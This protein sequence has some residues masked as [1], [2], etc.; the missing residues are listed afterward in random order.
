MAG[1]GRG[2][3]NN[4]Q[5]NQMNQMNQMGQMG[6]MG[7][8]N[9]AFMNQQMANMRAQPG[10]NMQGGMQQQMAMGNA[11]IHRQIIQNLQS[12]G[13]FSG[14]QAAVP[15]NERA[16][17]IRQLVDSLRLVRPPV[18]PPKAAEV[19]IQFE[20]KAFAQSASKEDYIRECNDKLA[21]IRDQRAQQM[22]VNG[23][24]AMQQGGMPMQNQAFMQQ[25]GQN[26]NISQGMS[27]SPAQQQMQQNMFNQQRSQNLQQT[28]VMQGQVT[29]QGNSGPKQPEGL[30]QEDNQIINQRAA[31]LAK[32]TPKDK[33]RGIV[34]NMNAQLRASLEAKGVDPIIYYFR[35]M[36]TK[37]FRRQ[38]EMANPMAAQQGQQGQGNF[39]DMGRFQSQQNEA[40]RSQQEG[41]MVVP[42]SN[43]Q[44]M[45]SDQLRLQ[46]QMMANNQRMGQQP[47]QAMLE[48]QRQMQIQANKMQQARQFGQQQ[49]ANNQGMAPNQTPQQNNAGF[50]M[51]N[52][53]VGA[54]SQDPS[55]QNSRPPSRVPQQPNMPQM[56]A[57]D[58]QK[59]E[60]M[61]ARFPPQL[62]NVLRQKPQNEWPGIIQNWQK[63]QQRNAQAGA[64]M[65]Q[66]A[67]QG[68]VNQGMPGP[69][70][71]QQSLSQGGMGQAE[72]N[73]AMQNM[74]QNQAQMN[75]E[76]MRQRAMQQQQQ[77]RMQG[78]AGK[79]QVQVRPL[80]QGE[81]NIMDRAPV[82]VAVLQ[83]IRDSSR[84]PLPNVP[85][86]NW[87][88]LK[89]WAQQNP[90]SGINLQTLLRWQATQYHTQK[91]RQQQQQQQQQQAQMQ[92]GQPQMGQRQ[93]PQQPQP[94][95]PQPQQPG[96]SAQQMNGA[97]NP[98][99]AEINRVRATYPKLAGMPDEQVRSLLIQRQKQSQQN[100]IGMAAN[101]QGMQQGQAMPGQQQAMQQVQ[102]AQMQQQK[103]A[104]QQPQQAQQPQRTPSQ[105]QTQMQQQVN[106]AQNQQAA[107]GKPQQGQTQMQQPQQR[108]ITKEQYEAMEPAQKAQ[109]LKMQQR[110]AIMRKIMA[111]TQEVQA[112]LPQAGPA[113]MDEAS[114]QRLA[115]RLG[116]DN[117]KQMMGRIDSF[118]VAYFD[119]VKNESELRKLI[120]YRALLYRQ[121]QQ[122]SIGDKSFVPS[123]NFSITFEKAEEMLN[124]LSTKFQQTAASI[125]KQNV[126]GQQLS[127]LTPENLKQHEEQQ[128]RKKSV[129]NKSQRDGP[130]AAPT[131][132]QPPFSFS[133]ERGHGAPKYATPGLK[134]EDLKLPIDPKRR[135]KNNAQPA[136][137]SG[138]AAG[139]TPT[140][141][142]PTPPQNK[143]ATAQAT[144]SAPARFP[145]VFKGCPR[146]IN[147]FATQAEVEQHIATTHGME[148]VSNPLAF[149]ESSL[150]EAFNLDENMK[151]LKKAQPAQSH[152]MAKSLS[153]NLKAESRAGTPMARIP[154][155]GAMPSPAAA[156]AAKA[157]E[158]SVEDLWGHSNISAD[159]LEGIFG[160]MEWENINPA[161]DKSLHDKFVQDYMESDDWK[162][163]F[164]S[165]SPDTARS[166]SASPPTG[167][168]AEPKNTAKPAEDF[169]VDMSGIDG[170]DITGVE[171]YETICDS[172]KAEGSSSP[173]EV[174]EKS[175]LSVAENPD[176]DATMADAST[177][178][179]HEYTF[180]RTHGV[181]PTKPYE[182]LTPSQKQLYDF[183]MDPM[184]GQE[185]HGMDNGTVDDEDDDWEDLL[186]IKPGK[187][188]HSHYP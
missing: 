58:Q 117:V 46:Q 119:M 129:G 103:P 177:E 113:A 94:G 134:Q 158:D 144:Q 173:F 186:T 53:P 176:G 167:K 149:L 130:P 25:M 14:W 43:N 24:M 118:L 61:L 137:P 13:P 146:Q 74:P 76:M 57:Q 128:E 67:N 84:A 29:A 124:E 181:D 28:P 41:D 150:R 77:Q 101:R 160:D 147:G 82:P 89:Q 8:M 110:Q 127:Q 142:T 27:M 102:M 64:A 66:Q 155:V 3:P 45:M 140:A 154:S 85:Q 126:Q 69:S 153:A 178:E 47:N 187:K 68:M 111:L 105:N 34:E 1:M 21:R 170:L 132:S 93:M 19:A 161:L 35:M 162:S 51:L 183:M 91:S 4:M 98:S 60:Q 88:T 56:T 40:Y 59:R 90:V 80:N 138:S 30:S 168:D 63:M 164:K 18:E 133:G 71:M 54:N 2:M 107:P 15:I 179:P 65:N 135:K 143:A 148:P 92:A 152:P 106:K 171:E 163:Q 141:P 83:P 33:M 17:Q 70:P 87:L 121:Y 100:Q 86:M 49:Q 114:R 120:E 180:L 184:P 97:Y 109:W 11:Q 169:T 116:A 96:G 165:S 6:Q 108:A 182:Q 99:I 42:A 50:N 9:P 78:E 23:N 172:F 37:E 36:A 145:C 115:Q 31:E 123:G 175:D 185:G 10:M 95:Q 26:M 136:T 125:P 79:P 20:R 122:K 72:M 62:Q 44:G 55:P 75:Q 73:V 32:S 5:M 52:R 112:A 157:P 159:Q 7:Q 39:T 104:Q 38:K 151:Q 139:Q 166:K 156:T 81:M 48:R 12:Q 188:Y 22:N 131:S 174:I 16:A